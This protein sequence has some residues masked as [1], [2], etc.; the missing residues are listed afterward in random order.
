MELFLSLDGGRAVRDMVLQEDDASEW[1]SSW[2]DVFPH[3]MKAIGQLL[4]PI[5]NHM[6]FMEFLMERFQPSAIQG[7][8]RLQQSWSLNF[9]DSIFFFGILVLLTTYNPMSCLQVR[10]EHVLSKILNGGGIGCYRRRRQG[11]SLDA[12]SR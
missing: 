5:G 10:M 2:L 6:T 7:Y 12:A 11:Q 4:W 9:I 3:F 1:T 8:V